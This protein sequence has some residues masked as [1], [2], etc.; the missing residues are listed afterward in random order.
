MTDVLESPVATQVATQIRH[1]EERLAAAQSHVARLQTQ[2][3]EVRH[4]L[5]S[6]AIGR[7]WCDDLNNFLEGVGYERWEVEY[8][9]TFSYTTTVTMSGCERDD[10]EAT[11][12]AWEQMRD[13]YTQGEVS[14]GVEQ[15]DDNH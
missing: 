1:L 4:A 3:D 9:V 7:G 12:R 14:I 11:A 2:H 13:A 8:Q 6:E 10:D 5:I 15:T